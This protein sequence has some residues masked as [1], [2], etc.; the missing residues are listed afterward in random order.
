VE[1]IYIILQ[2]F[3]FRKL[4]TKF[5]QNRPS[6]IEDITENV[7]VSFFQNFPDTVLLSSLNVRQFLLSDVLHCT[8]MSADFI[9]FMK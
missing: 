1:N 3:F 4:H 7:L 9:D 5:Y 8:N 2:Q 6:F